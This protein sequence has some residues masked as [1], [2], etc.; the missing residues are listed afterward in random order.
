M[1]L[2]CLNGAASRKVG[3]IARNPLG[4]LLELP[5]VE[6]RGGDAVWPKATFEM[7][8]KAANPAFADMVRILAWTEAR[9]STVCKE[10]ARHYIAS[11]KLW[12]V[13]D[14]Y[15][16]RRS[17]RGQPNR[18]HSRTGHSRTGEHSRTG[19]IAYSFRRTGENRAEPG[20]SPILF[21]RRG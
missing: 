12:D 15:R 18:G 11:L 17:K 1:I 5:E 9:P 2:A 16:G 7:V 21:A 20:T 10:E 13:E 8:C 6:S 3:L 19:D 14:L 4:G